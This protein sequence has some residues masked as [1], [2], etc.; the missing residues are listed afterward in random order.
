MYIFTSTYAGQNASKRRGREACAPR[1]TVKKKAYQHGFRESERVKTHVSGVVEAHA[2]VEVIDRL[3]LLLGKVELDVP[4]V[5]ADELG[6]GGLGDDDDALLGRPPEEDLSSSAVVLLGDLEDRLV[7]EQ[8]RALVRALPIELTEGEGTEGGVGHDGDLLALSE[9][10][11]V[12]LDEVGV[13]LCEVKMSVAR[14]ALQ[15][16]DSPIW[17]TDGGMRA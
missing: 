12:L 8:Q 5:L 10:H 15:Q 13:V 2:N 16:M 1:S 11:E 17:R 7:L 4:E 3:D 14:T 6:V 9:L